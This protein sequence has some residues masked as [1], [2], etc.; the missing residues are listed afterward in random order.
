LNLEKGLSGY[1]KVKI[2]SPTRRIMGMLLCGLKFPYIYGVFGRGVEENVAAPFLFSR[3]LVSNKRGVDRL[4][5]S[6]NGNIP[7]IF[8]ILPLHQNDWTQVLSREVSLVSSLSSPPLHSHMALQPNK[9]NIPAPFY[10]TI[11]PNKK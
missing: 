8:G 4:L 10:S 9:K 1:R 11:Q 5:K 6:P 7:K 2:F 3:Y